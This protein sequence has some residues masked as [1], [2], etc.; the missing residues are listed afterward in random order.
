MKN[1][2]NNLD[3]A[4]PKQLKWEI[5]RDDE[6]NGEQWKKNKG[7]KFS[8]KNDFHSKKKSFGNGTFKNKNK[9]SNRIRKKH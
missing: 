6:M 2:I 5:K 7:K 3:K 1:Y 9:V 4:D 8:K